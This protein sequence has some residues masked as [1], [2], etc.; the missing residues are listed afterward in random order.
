MTAAV[1]TRIL[2]SHLSYERIFLLLF[3]IAL[4]ARFTLLDLKLFHHDEAVHAWFS[5]RLQTLGTYSY[6]PVYHGPFLYYVTAGMFSLFGTSD[7]VGRIIPALAGAL[8]IPLVYPIYRLGYIGGR[9]AVGAALFLAVSPDMVYFSRFLRNDIFIVFFSL[10]LLV[11]ALYYF[12]RG[13]RKYLIIGAAAA[14]LGMCAKENMPIVIATFGS[15]LVYAVWRRTLILPRRWKADLVIGIM[16]AAGI[17]VVFYSSFLQHPEILA[18][19]WLRAIEH[20][21]SMHQQQRLGGPPY[22]YLLLFVLYELPVLLLAGCAVLQFLMSPA[23]GQPGTEENIGGIDAL[24]NRML[25]ASLPVPVPAMDRQNEFMR[26]CIYWMITSVVIYAYIGEK[27]PWLILHQLLPLI[28]VAVYRLDRD[29]W[30]SVAA[31]GAVIFL[32]VMTLH[33]AFTP[34]DI[35]EPIVQV[36]NSEDLRTIMALIDA[37]ATVAITTD[38]YWPLPWYYRGQANSH[39]AYLTPPVSPETLRAR[40]FDLII[41]HDLESYPSLPGYEKETYRHSYWFSTHDN[42]DRLLAYYFTRE[43]ITGSVNWDVFVRE[44]TPACI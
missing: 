35:N 38:N 10:V 23:R 28:F 33:V 32:V 19:G 37:S 21:T 42:K 15:Y 7:L 8:L 39:I 13:E 27:V 29:R 5:W 31:A 9:Q 16:V 34:A 40:D 36:Q 14:G 17:M 1:F 43:G 2:R 41:A 6:D 11:A 3:L 25:R 24:F 12:E 20:W 44:N 22:F 26:F 18:D 30:K 4:I